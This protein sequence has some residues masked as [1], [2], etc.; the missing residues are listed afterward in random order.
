MERRLA[1]ILAA[2]M[3]GYSRLVASDEAG[4]IER[5]KLH[6]ATLIDPKIAQYGGRIVKT[7][8][9]GMLVEFTSVVDA[10]QCAVE[11]QQAMPQREAQVADADPI[12]Y[13]VG[14]NLGDI[15]I[16]GD[17]ILGDGVNIAARLESL[18][19]PGGI[20]I[21]RPVHTQIKGKLDL[22]F[23]DLGEKEVKN[24][25]EPVAVYRVM[26]DHKTAAFVTP[27]AQK[28]AKRASRR[29]AIAALA[30]APLVVGVIGVF[31]WQ[32]WKPDVEPASL[33]RMAFPLPQEAS[34]AVLPFQNLSDDPEQEY[35]ADG[36]TNDII[37][38]LSRMKDLFVIASNSTFTYKDKPVKVQKVAE[39]LGVRYV[40]EG[41]VQRAG[42]TVRINAQ[43]IDAITG[44]HLWADRYERNATDL[45]AV[46]AEIIETIVATLAFKVDTIERDR[47][48][49]KDTENLAAYELYRR[50]REAFFVWTK[51]D[52]AEARELSERAIE[53]DPNYMQ[54]YALMAR[55]LGVQ[56]QSG[57][58][59]DPDDTRDL[60]IEMGRK[61]VA[62]SPD[63]YYSHWELGGAYMFKG[64]FDRAF[65]EYE[66]ALTLNPNDADL[67]AEMVELLVKTGK[68]EDAVVQIKS[69]MR[70]NPHYPDWY[71]WNLGWSQYF[72]G[73]YAEALAALNQMSN[74]PNAVR[75]H[76]AAVLV[77]LGRV[78][79]AR[80]VI[81]AF[82]AETPD[83]TL[84]TEMAYRWQHRP[85][86]D[87]LIDDLRTAGLP[88]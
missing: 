33:E 76:L 48:L 40:L 55:I 58:V 61:A 29:W 63:D 8:G 65:S 68:A 83:H 27:I 46:Q 17:D 72:A 60:A 82:V 88:E 28:A 23:E 34:I 36:L 14:I 13:R 79:E 54:P 22:N 87:K 50:A 86:L 66:R 3:V 77:R 67:L 74:P 26:L 31:L 24:I 57:W 42:D 35:F 10:V 62:L 70:I 6:R 19:E 2:D 85:Y 25:P 71:L 30:A 41:S 44:R 12:Q 52:M 20:C 21:S 84:S 43:L 59:D 18:A 37:T 4:T 69:A 51:A 47:V 5:Q 45:F 38:D 39:E 15:V 9:D 56:A 7:T 11:I 64:D 1:A 73:Q 78:E 16:D 32:P 49:L 81:E 75:R 53:L 80:K